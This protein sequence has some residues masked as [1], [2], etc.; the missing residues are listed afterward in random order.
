MGFDEGGRICTGKDEEKRTG[1]KSRGRGGG[2]NGP[3]AGPQER[4]PWKPGRT[5]SMWPAC[6]ANISGL[7]AARG[8]R[9]KKEL[10]LNG[11]VINPKHSYSAGRVD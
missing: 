6:Q 2:R 8:L 10:F 3:P 9:E 5:G 11:K 7:G 1:G 4:G